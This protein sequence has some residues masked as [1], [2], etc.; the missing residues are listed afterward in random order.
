MALHE[1]GIEEAVAPMGTAL[2]VEQV[3]ALGRLA[4]TVTVVF[5]G[6][7]AGQRAAQ[8]AVPLFVDGDVDGRVARLPAGFDP[9]DFVRSSDDGAGR[10]P[11]HGR[12]R[13][14]DA[15]SVHPG[16]RR[17]PSSIEGKMATLERV[18]ELLVRVRNQT[19]RELYAGQLAGVLGLTHPAG[20][21]RAAGSGGARPPRRATRAA[22]RRPPRPAADAGRRAGQAAAGRASRHR[23]AGP[24]PGA[25]AHARGGA[26]GRAAAPP[27]AAPAPPRGRRAG[28]RDRQAR[29][30]GLAGRRARRAAQDGR[31]RR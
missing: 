5:D 3:A 17:G 10:L 23:P 26:R 20:Q 27:D 11:A 22:P 4:K 12:R 30:A 7:T 9:D 21:A 19:K 25:L 13:A 6:D 14:P 28:R 15:R 31:R 18:A 2:T 8:K 1:A 24:L 29:R 16:Q